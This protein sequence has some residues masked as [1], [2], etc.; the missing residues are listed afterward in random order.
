MCDCGGRLEGLQLLMSRQSVQEPPQ[1]H[2]LTLHSGDDAP[3]AERQLTQFPHPYPTLRGLQVYDPPLTPTLPNPMRPA[4]AH[5]LLSL[6]SVEVL[7]CITSGRCRVA[8]QCCSWH[9][10]PPVPLPV[11]DGA[12]EAA[13]CH[14]SR[15]SK[16][17]SAAFLNLKEEF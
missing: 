10:S 3:A 2:I 1:T 15:V 5:S 8:A 7:I 17:G 14:T 16:V 13:P 4:G 12:L 11:C 9:L 6:Q